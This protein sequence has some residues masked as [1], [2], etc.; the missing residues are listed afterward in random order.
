MKKAFTLS[1]VIVTLSV[2]GV[3]AALT[4]PT[5]VKNYRYKLYASQLQKTYSQIQTAIKTI[6]EDEITSDFYKTTAGAENDVT[7][8]KKGVC[9]FLNNYFKLVRENCG[10]G[11][12]KCVAGSYLSTKKANA[13]YISN[14]SDPYCGQ[15]ING[16]AIC[17]TN[18]PANHITTIFIDINGPEA[19]N[20]TGI[21]AFVMN[22][23]SDGQLKDWSNNSE[24]C[25]T[26]HSS[27]GHIADYATGCLTKV[28]ND[29]WV[30]K[31]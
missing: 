21:D 1:E 12:K 13:G 18:N 30:I 9:Y 25:N 8:C 20:I 23:T 22:F 19:P 31:D 17:M 14:G 27:Y 4:I 28:I 24:H 11:T 26:K 29:G 15:T 6:M 2:I 10:S 7:N 16:A 5:V 3:V